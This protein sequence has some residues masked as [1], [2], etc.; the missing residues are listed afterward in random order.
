MFGVET[1]R[2][3]SW[4]R[5]DFVRLEIEAAIAHDVRIVPVLVAGA[6]MPASTALPDPIAALTRKEAAE[7]SDT[8]WSY[9]VDRLV[10]S[11]QP[12]RSPHRR[13]QVALGGLTAA[14]VIAVAAGI[15]LA[16]GSGGGGQKTSLIPVSFRQPLTSTTAGWPVRKEADCT[17]AFPPA[18]TGYQ[19]SVLRTK[20]VCISKMSDESGFDALVDS[21]TEVDATLV[22]ADGDLSDPNNSVLLGLDCRLKGGGSYLMSAFTDGRVLLSRYAPGSPDATDL[23]GG[24]ISPFA[25]GERHRLR[26]DCVQS[27]ADRVTLTAWV[28]GT[29]IVST[30]DQQQLVAAGAIALEVGTSNLPAVAEFRNLSVRGTSAKKP[31]SQTTASPRP[32]LPPDH[33][34]P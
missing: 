21:H 33:T 22:T 17:T 18:G 27:G 28:D 7:L 3:G 25:V 9:D 4:I 26:F 6:T 10:R 15:V 30:Q 16:M 24:L 13:R 20:W 19:V 8:R 1:D 12:A 23:K 31:H 32:S 5:N 14:A 11:V 29:R 34:I 2:A